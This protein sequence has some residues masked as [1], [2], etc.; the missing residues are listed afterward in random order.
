MAGECSPVRAVLGDVS[1]IDFP[2]EAAVV[3]FTAGCN[4][5]CG[6]CH[7]AGLLGRG[8][9]ED[10]RWGVLWEKLERFRGNWVSAVVV[11]GGEPTI[12]PG[13]G[14]LVKRLK[15]AG[16]RVKLD[17]NGSRPGVLAA[18]LPTVDYVAMDLKCAAAHYEGR[19]GFGDVGAIERSMRLL[20]GWGGEYE[21]RTTVLEAW[22]DAAEMG[23]MAVWAEGARRYVLQG[24]LPRGDLPLAAYRRM[25][26]TSGAHIRAMAEIIRPHVGEV[27]IRGG[28]GVEGIKSG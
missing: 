17:T 7:N 3:C 1:L 20:A 15:G 28:R 25:G 6:Y 21:L 11:T 4:F 16:F 13:I 9:G 19:V 12:R 5:R 14:E 24:F 26:E 22:H 23:A 27:V 18:L 10:L 2:G 8:M